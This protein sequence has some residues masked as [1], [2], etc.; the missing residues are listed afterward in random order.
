MHFL[1]LSEAKECCPH[2]PWTG[3]QKRFSMTQAGTFEKEEQKYTSGASSSGTGWQEDWS[4][5][6]RAAQRGS[7]SVVGGMGVQQLTA[8]LC[9]LG[10]IALWLPHLFE[11][12]AGGSNYM[13]WISCHWLVMKTIHFP[14][15]FIICRF[16]PVRQTAF[17]SL[18]LLSKSL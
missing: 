6:P 9:C 12:S 13:A 5:L 14:F 4:S 17:K 18:L 10:K 7:R 3:M 1:F 15:S 8:S 11:F 16:S 2:C